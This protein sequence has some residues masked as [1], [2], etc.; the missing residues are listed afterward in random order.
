MGL[1]CLLTSSMNSDDGVCCYPRECILEGNCVEEGY[2]R[3]DG[4]V[5][6]GGSWLSENETTTSTTLATTITE[7]TFDEIIWEKEEHKNVFISYDSACVNEPVKIKAQDEK[8][9]PLKNAVFSIKIGGSFSGYG[10]VDDAGEFSFTPEETGEYNIKVMRGDYFGVWNITVEVC[11][12][13]EIQ[14][15]TSFTVSL[16]AEKEVTA[17][18]EFN[19]TV[20][21]HAKDDIGGVNASIY[22]PEGFS[23]EHP[24]IRDE[25][26]IRKG[27]NKSITWHV[28]TADSLTPGN[29]SLKVSVSPLTADKRD[30]SNSTTIQVHEQKKDLI[31]I[32]QE[33]T[34]G[35]TEK[36]YEV[37]SNPPTWTILLLLLLG[38]SYIY[39]SKAHR[40]QAKK[41]EAEEEIKKAAQT[42]TKVEG[43]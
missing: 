43:G 37:A 18:D 28:K 19:I 16:S 12:E 39:Y 15:K 36:V 8:G 22:L 31:R 32:I 26:E 34:Y 20:E 33:N 24:S 17:G 6:Q 40:R 41:Q 42:K 4:R 29:Y 11:E 21:I 2:R 38:L 13:G 10:E 23:V 30:I 7:T 9:N 1:N 3:V 27:E 5:C 25:T 35:F 14:K